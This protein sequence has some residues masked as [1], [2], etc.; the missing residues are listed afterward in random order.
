[1][2]A[3]RDEEELRHIA[4]PARDEQ[5]AEGPNTDANAPPTET[6]APPIADLAAR[7]KNLT[8]IVGHLIKKKKKPAKRSALYQVQV[9]PL[10]FLQIQIPIQTAQV[11]LPSCWLLLK[12]RLIVKRNTPR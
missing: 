7:V 8:E 4:R 6:Q 9:N 10:N 5:D 3:R 1:M 12:R 11:A 2:R